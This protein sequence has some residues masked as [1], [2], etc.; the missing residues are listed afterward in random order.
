VAEGPAE[1]SS[2]GAVVRPRP[3]HLRHHADGGL[4]LVSTPASC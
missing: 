4:A 1:Y 2:R 3:G